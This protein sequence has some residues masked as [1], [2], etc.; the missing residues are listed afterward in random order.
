MAEAYR[1]IAECFQARTGKVLELEILPSAFQP[2]PTTQPSSVLV[3]G[4]SVGVFKQALI[5]ALPHARAAFQVLDDRRLPIGD[6]VL[7]ASHVLLLFDPEFLTAANARKRRLL[8][9]KAA[10]DRPG[11]GQGQG[12]GALHRAV[13]DEMA[14]LDSFFTSPLHRHTKSPTLWHHRR[15]IVSTFYPELRHAPEKAEEP[16]E[17]EQGFHDAEL[18]VVIKAGER[19][20]KNYYAWT[21]ARWL[22]TFLLRSSSTTPSLLVEQSILSTA[23]DKVTDW[24]LRNP[25]DVSGWDF[26]WYLLGWKAPSTSPPPALPISAPTPPTQPRSRKYELLEHILNVAMTYEWTHEAAW[27]FLRTAIASDA[28]LTLRERLGLLAQLRISRNEASLIALEAHE[29]GKVCDGMVERTVLWIETRTG[30]ELTDL[31]R[32]GSMI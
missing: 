16:V 4:C 26:L 3:D 19:H 11:Q 21:Y 7:N 30:G 9:L 25:S 18:A 22:L 29:T 23:T 27:A 6:A 31:A 17:A 14:V 8:A 5:Q 12:Q 10:A 15:W 13:R 20:P 24:C 28:A 32:E 1:S 2:S